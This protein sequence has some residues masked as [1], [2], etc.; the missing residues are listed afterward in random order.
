LEERWLRL[1]SSRRL[2]C[3]PGTAPPLSSTLLTDLSRIM[4]Q[5][6]YKMF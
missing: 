1:V 4:K 5:F 2:E 6:V 3:N